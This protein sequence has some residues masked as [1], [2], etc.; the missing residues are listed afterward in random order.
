MAG[1]NDIM[2]KKHSRFSEDLNSDQHLGETEE[3]NL[4]SRGDG[5][6]IVRRGN[7]I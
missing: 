2:V 1:R 3:D 7:T 5:K 4:R 6:E